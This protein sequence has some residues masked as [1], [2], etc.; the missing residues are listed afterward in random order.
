MRISWGILSWRRGSESNRRM[1]LLQSRALPL[2]YPARGARKIERR[3]RGARF[4]FFCRRGTGWL[5]SASTT[6]PTLRQ[7]PV[8]GASARCGCHCRARLK[9]GRQRDAVMVWELGRPAQTSVP[10]SGLSA[11]GERG[12]TEFSVGGR[13][14]P[15]RSARWV[16]ADVR[17]WIGRW[18]GPPPPHVGGYGTAVRASTAESSRALPR[19]PVLKNAA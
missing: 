11:A 1:Q 14:L 12:G 5:T 8:A 17:R 6:R 13:K 15:A 9:P 4:C 7:E 16:A 2:G 19:F 10:R 18:A 3:P